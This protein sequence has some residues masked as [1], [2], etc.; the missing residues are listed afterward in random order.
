MKNKLIL[1]Y[2]LY[3]VAVALLLSPTLLWFYWNRE[4]YFREN[5]VNLSIGAILTLFSIVLLL[6]GSLKEIN[7]N[8]KPIFWLGILLGITYFI[9]SI[10]NDLFWI[11]LCA[12]VGYIMFAI[13]NPFAM[14]NI[15][16]VK[17][18]MNEKA[19]IEARSDFNAG[20][21]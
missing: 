7:G 10:L 17:V 14:R 18:Y 19:R 11:I 2:S 1:G 12:L 9:E 16:Y 6:K 15:N 4:T 21:V 3:V 20:N 5:T 13:L 8:I